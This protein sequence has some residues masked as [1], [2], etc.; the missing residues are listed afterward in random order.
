MFCQNFKHLTLKCP[1][2][3]QGLLEHYKF[4]SDTNTRMFIYSLLMCVYWQSTV[5]STLYFNPDL[6]ALVHEPALAEPE[7]ERRCLCHVRGGARLEQ[8]ML[9]A[10]A[11]R[12]RTA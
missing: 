9:Q 2:R 8:G 7:P 10:S 1:V 11:G 5:R 4:Q 12:S 6:L 3:P